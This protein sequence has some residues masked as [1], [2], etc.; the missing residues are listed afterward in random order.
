MAFGDASRSC[1]TAHALVPLLDHCRSAQLIATHST[2]SLTRCSESFLDFTCLPAFQLRRSECLPFPR[3]WPTTGC[4]A[5]RHCLPCWLPWRSSRRVPSRNPHR[6]HRC[7]SKRPRRRLRLQL[8]LR[9]RRHEASRQ[10]AVIAPQYLTAIETALYALKREAV[11]VVDGADVAGLRDRPRSRVRG[12]V[13]AGPAGSMSSCS[14]RAAGACRSGWSRARSSAGLH[15][16]RARRHHGWSPGSCSDPAR[17]CRDV[18][19]HGHHLPRRNDHLDGGIGCVSKAHPIL[20]Y[21][22]NMHTARAN[23]TAFT[24]AGIPDD[25]GDL[26]GGGATRPDPGGRRRARRCWPARAPA[27]SSDS[28]G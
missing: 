2:G 17:V 8:R 4:S 12:S 14:G 11:P 3:Q 22:I 1:A 25:I 15:T 20:V 24:A 7:R 26:P 18:A 28:P 19:G 13:C 10:G 16:A 6:L 9:F 5:T 23:G 21:Y 27:G